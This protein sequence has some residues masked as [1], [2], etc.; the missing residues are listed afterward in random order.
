MYC[1]AVQ[2]NFN[3]PVASG[4]C[5]FRHRFLRRLRWPVGEL[6]AHIEP[7]L[8]FKRRF[9]RDADR[10]WREQLE[11]LIEGAEGLADPEIGLI[12]GQLSPEFGWGIERRL[13]WA[14]SVLERTVTDPEASRRWAEAI[15]SISDPDDC[16]QYEG[17]VIEPQLGLVVSEYEKLERHVVTVTPGADSTGVPN[18]THSTSA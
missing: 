7:T 2:K 1:F 13:A 5:D 17:L 11:E 16:P 6:A 9:E 18:L 10:W 4:R 12:D 15:R 14:R 3:G 8:G